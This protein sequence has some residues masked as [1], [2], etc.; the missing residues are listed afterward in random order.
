[1]RFSDSGEPAC[2][3]HTR[4]DQHHMHDTIFAYPPFGIYRLPAADAWAA[5]SGHFWKLMLGA[6]PAAYVFGCLQQCPEQ[7][8]IHKGCRFVGVAPLRLRPIRLTDHAS[9]M[10]QTTQGHPVQ[11]IVL[12]A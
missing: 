1:M 11:V 7:P 10:K 5:R 12:G 2:S 6:S 3:G 8:C 4:Q 9:V